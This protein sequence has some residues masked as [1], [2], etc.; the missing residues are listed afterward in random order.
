MNRKKLHTL[1]EVINAGVGGTLQGLSR[2]EERKG[3]LSD[4]ENKLV[5]ELK[6]EKISDLE[7][8]AKILRGEISI[9]K[10]DQTLLDKGKS[11]F[12]V[13]SREEQALKEKLKQIYREIDRLSL[14][15]DNE[16]TPQNVP[17]ISKETYET[18]SSIEMQGE[19]ED[20]PA[21]PLEDINGQRKNLYTLL[22]DL[23][24]KT[25]KENVKKFLKHIPVGLAKLGTGLGGILD[26][27]NLRDPSLEQEIS[28]KYGVEYKPV[29]YK[30]LAEKYLEQPVRNLLSLEENDNSLPAQL[31]EFVGSLASPDPISK[32]LKG[33]KAARHS[34][35]ILQRMLK[36]GQQGAASAA[37]YGAIQAGN[38]YEGDREKFVKESIQDVIP[39]AGLGAILSAFGGKGGK[40]GRELRK[41][42][43]NAGI[44]DE[45]VIRHIIENSGG[46]LTIPEVVRDKAG[47]ARINQDRSRANAKRMLQADNE[48][49]STYR[50]MAEKL[51]QGEREEFYRGVKNL[52]KSWHDKGSPLYDEIKDVV[53]GNQG[54]LPENVL[55]DFFNVV[56]EAEKMGLKGLPSLKTG[57][58]VANENGLKEIRYLLNEAGTSP[59]GFEGFVKE[60]ADRVPLAEDFLNFRKEIKERLKK[61]LKGT[62]G[63]TAD[64]PALKVLSKNLE[65]IIEKEGAT[66]AFRKAD[67]F[68]AKNVAPFSKDKK[69]VEAF[70]SLGD[71]AFTNG[72]PDIF[73]VFKTANKN[74]ARVFALLPT[75]D[76]KR[77]IGG[78]LEEAR[79]KHSPESALEKIWEKLP[80]YIK[81]TEDQAVQALLKE[82]EAVSLAREARTGLQ[83][84]TDKGIGSRGEV[85]K[86]R[87]AFSLN[88][89]RWTGLLL[90]QV[91]ASRGKAYRKKVSARN[92]EEY[93][94]PRLLESR[95]P[96]T[97]REIRSL[98]E[99]MR[100]PKEE[101]EDG[102]R[103][104]LKTSPKAKRN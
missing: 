96:S 3:K 55:N 73:E 88:P 17:A 5:K 94:D 90:D 16:K 8:R 13:A 95:V 79:K 97:T 87:R 54:Q 53:L 83:K 84:M 46:N 2:A 66:E 67:H 92:L 68:W 26:F 49:V 37:T 39:G 93:L 15:E 48:L 82:L 28:D 20:L 27:I 4:R 30:E 100:S 29:S 24:N 9:A 65:D 18:P 51:P 50:K 98:I 101:Q 14:G 10:S 22:K 61:S 77:V 31:G 60:N 47:I 35:K 86:L 6:K 44:K 104:E 63:S 25:E 41:T 40:L 23:P 64:V 36:G 69:I 89:L 11:F 1:L 102:L 80:T 21:T 103:I 81:E 45:K 85:E 91:N 57:R 62:G 78:F 43:E 52:E 32:G 33:A 7:R 72:A 74:N 34:S 19:I 56:A 38:N 76:K 59:K 75:D 99:L 70:D 12:G 71:P 58:G 42:R